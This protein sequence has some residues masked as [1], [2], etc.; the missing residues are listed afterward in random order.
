MK[1][2]CSA[3]V[4]D[5]QASRAS[6]N[7]LVSISAMIDCQRSTGNSWIGAT[8]CT[9]ALATTRSRR[10]KRSSAA[11]DRVGVGLGSVRSAS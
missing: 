3:S 1:L 11:V 4:S 6:T 10:P 5:G 2:P 8:C 7:G 9:P